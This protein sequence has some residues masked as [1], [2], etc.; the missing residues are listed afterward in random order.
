MLTL[1]QYSKAEAAEMVKRGL[2]QLPQAV[3]LFRTPFVR[4]VTVRFG[5]I[6]DKKKKKNV[7]T[8]EIFIGLV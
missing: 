2:F 8:N 5:L 4:S 7:Q 1:Q 6:F 3:I